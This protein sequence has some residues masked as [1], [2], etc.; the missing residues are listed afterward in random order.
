[1]LQEDM[2]LIRDYIHFPEAKYKQ[3]YFREFN[4]EFASILTYRSI[5]IDYTLECSYS[6]HVSSN[7]EISEVHAA[8]ICRVEGSMTSGC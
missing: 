8:S 2:H 1:M 3:K 4:N 5:S 6:V 7:S